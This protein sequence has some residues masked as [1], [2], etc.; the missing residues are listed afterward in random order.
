MGLRCE[1]MIDRYGVLLT[2][3]HQLSKKKKSKVF[4]ESYKMLINSLAL[5]TSTHSFFPASYFSP[6]CLIHI[7]FV[8]FHVFGNV[9]F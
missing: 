1:F 3:S 7:Y 5:L 8:L 4:T 9:F 2:L 6:L